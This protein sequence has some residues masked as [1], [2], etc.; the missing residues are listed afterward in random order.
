[1]LY[2]THQ[3]GRRGVQELRFKS[4]EA[5]R[6]MFRRSSLPLKCRYLFT[7]QHCWIFQETRVFVSIALR[8]SVI[9]KQWN[10]CCFLQLLVLL[11]IFLRRGPFNAVMDRQVLQRGGFSWLLNFKG[12]LCPVE[13]V[14]FIS[15]RPE[16]FCTLKRKCVD[17]ALISEW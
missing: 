3:E 12:E 14:I 7:T 13:L 4:Y 5:R 15:V 8:T 2:C 11:V 6:R 10:D 17:I 16:K 1:M 9:M